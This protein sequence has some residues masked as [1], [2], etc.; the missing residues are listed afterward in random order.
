LL[1][2]SIEK[3]SINE[4]ESYPSPRLKSDRLLEKEDCHAGQKA[5]CRCFG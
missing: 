2:P 1:L 4:S 3:E 5:R